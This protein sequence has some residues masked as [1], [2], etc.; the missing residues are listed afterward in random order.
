MKHSSA[1]QLTP[2][3]LRNLLVAGII[4]LFALGIGLF[5]LT[6]TQLQTYGKEVSAKNSE[7]IASNDS[8]SRL[9]ATK[10]FLDN[11]TALIDQ[12]NLFTLNRDLPQFQIRNDI[13]HYAQLRNLS[14]TSIELGSADAGTA[15][16]PT[17]P[18]AAPSSSAPTTTPPVAASGSGSGNQLAATVTFSEDVEYAALLRFLYDIEHNLPK[19]TIEKVVLSQGEDG[20][21]VKVEPLIIKTHIT[22]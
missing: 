3:T 10:G 8:L 11:N 22:K 17:T 4:L 7:A 19:M 15:T 21:S 18:G 1:K 13:L 6:Y 9:Q 5:W 14:P 2:T 16:T 20:N 12:L